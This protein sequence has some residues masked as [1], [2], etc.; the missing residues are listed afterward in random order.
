MSGAA[1]M[2]I[3]RIPCHRSH[4]TARL[5]LNARRHNAAIHMTTTRPTFDGVNEAVQ[6]LWPYRSPTPLYRSVFG[7]LPPAGNANDLLPLQSV[8]VHVLCVFGMRGH[9]RH[10]TTSVVPQLGYFHT[11]R[12]F[13]QTLGTSTVSTNLVLIG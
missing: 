13:V 3:A 1:D 9:T 4:G 10:P 6:R 7:L 2:S 11:V 5:P 8:I 12:D